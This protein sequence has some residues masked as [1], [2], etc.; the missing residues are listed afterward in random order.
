MRIHKCIHT[1]TRIAFEQ[2]YFHNQ[3]YVHTYVC[4]YCRMNH[5][6][7]FSPSGEINQRWLIV[8]ARQ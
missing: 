2:M 4:I 6:M 3:L 7:S 1:H 8:G 5:Q